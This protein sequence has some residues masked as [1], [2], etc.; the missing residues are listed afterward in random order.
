MATASFCGGSGSPPYNARRRGPS[1]RRLGT[2]VG[3]QGHI[4]S[5]TRRR[6]NSWFPT[7]GAAR[8]N[9]RRCPWAERGNARTA[10]P[11]DKV[12]AA[13]P[14]SRSRSCTCMPCLRL[15]RYTM[16][17]RRR[18]PARR[19]RPRT[20]DN[21]WRRRAARSSPSREGHW[22]TSLPNTGRASGRRV[23]VGRPHTRSAPCRRRRRSPMPG[24]TRGT[25]PRRSPPR[26]P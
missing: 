2:L 22:P 26:R 9:A 17:V 7:S 12:S 8:G 11:P 25:G 23:H 6:S 16:N 18:R 19:R 1:R 15:R 20:T 13:H 21:R 4:G 5:G 10:L 24:R 14:R 3:R